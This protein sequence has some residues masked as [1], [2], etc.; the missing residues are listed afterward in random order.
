MKI[1]Q[2]F[3]TIKANLKKRWEDYWKTLAKYE[4]KFGPVWDSYDTNKDIWLS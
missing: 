4:K 2:F 3:K 1:I